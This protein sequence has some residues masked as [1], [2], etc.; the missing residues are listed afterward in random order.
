MTKRK[1]KQLYADMD[2]IFALRRAKEKAE[3]RY[4]IKM[5]DRKATKIIAPFVER[6][7]DPN[8]D[9]EIIEKK[10]YRN[11]FKIF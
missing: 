11:A 5:T 10:K 6:I 3:K 7:F 9:L 2:F 8:D 1:A 4:D